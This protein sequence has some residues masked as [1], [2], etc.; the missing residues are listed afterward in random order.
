MQK[1]AYTVKDLCHE[2]GI[3]RTKIYQLIKEDKMR[4]RKLGKRTVFLAKDVEA[5]LNNLPPMDGTQ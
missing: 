5:F 1:A 4:A 3:G 2:T